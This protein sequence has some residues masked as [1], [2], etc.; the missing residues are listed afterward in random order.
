MRPRRHDRP[1][2]QGIATIVIRVAAAQ[3]ISAPLPVESLTLSGLSIDRSISR[4]SPLSSP[5]PIAQMFQNE[6]A[7]G[8]LSVD[9]A[10]RMPNQSVKR[11]L[12]CAGPTNWRDQGRS[13]SPRPLYGRNQPVGRPA[14]GFASAYR[15]CRNRLDFVVAAS[16]AVAVKMSRHG[17]IT[18]LLDAASLI[19]RGFR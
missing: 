10:C 2:A 6:T 9:P 14:H 5:R 3:P 8:D 17:L 12:A 18:G 16:I 4:C 15:P 11:A 19:Q 7:I 1:E 13:P